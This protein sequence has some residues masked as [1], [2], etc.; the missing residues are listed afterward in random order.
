MLSL[1]EKEVV[2]KKKWI[3]SEEMLDM[4]AISES[5]PGAISLNLAT[6]VGV[7][8]KGVLGALFATAGLVIPS[9]IVISVISLF[10]VEFLEIK[11][12]SY[13]FRGIRVGVVVLIANAFVKFAKGMKKDWFSLL[14]FVTAFLLALFVTDLDIVFIILGAMVIGIGYGILRKAIAKKK[15]PKT[16]LGELNEQ[17]TADTAPKT[18][19]ENNENEQAQNQENRARDEQL[20]I[21]AEKLRNKLLEKGGKDDLS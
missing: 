17:E 21:S 4:L 16:P 15:T 14:L 1:I 7:R 18:Q 13:A 6:F 3:E 19:E 2:E 11:V 9:F 10:I 5:T 8:V 12:I 20:K